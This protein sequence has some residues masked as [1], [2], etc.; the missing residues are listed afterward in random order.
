MMM[1]GSC[2]FVFVWNFFGEFEKLVGETVS[3]FCDFI[4]GFLDHMC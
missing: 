2:L 1:Y 3:Y 4:L